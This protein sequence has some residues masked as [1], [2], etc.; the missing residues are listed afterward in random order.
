MSCG[1]GRRCVLALAWLWHRLAA[2]SLIR[3]LAWEPP[4]AM[5]VALKR[6]KTKNKTLYFNFLKKREFPLCYSGLV[7]QLVFV[8]VLVWSLACHSGLRI[9]HCC[10][11]GV[12]CSSSSD[13]IPGLGIS[14]HHGWGPKREKKKGIASCPKWL[15]IFPS[16]RNVWA[17]L[18]FPIL[19]NT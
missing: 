11:C 4:C 10:S 7:I 17:F 18:L 2:T 5:D 12:G 3:P 6:Q 19:A 8:E 16:S 13:S 14:I 15:M 1:V 9:W